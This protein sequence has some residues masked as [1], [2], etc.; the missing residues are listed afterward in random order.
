MKEIAIYGKGG[1]GKSTISANTS[2]ALSAMGKNVLQ[3]GCDPKHDSTRL[4]LEGRTINTVL[5]YLKVTNPLKYQLND[6]LYRGFNGIGCIEAGGPEPGVGCAG[7]GIL[8]TFE[9]LD[10]LNLKKNDY[11]YIIY[12][13]LGD[14]VCGG[15]AVP[16]RREYADEIYIVTSG[17]FMSLY[18]ANNI[19]RGIKNYVDHQKR[20]GGLI[21]NERKLQGEAERVQGFA[22]AVGLPVYAQIPRDDVFGLCEKLGKTL[23]EA[24]PYCKTAHVFKELA[25]DI[26]KG[27]QLYEAAP[28][29][30]SE[31]ENIVLGNAASVK[32]VK[33]GYEKEEIQGNIEIPKEEVFL[34]KSIV[35]QEPLHGCAFNGAITM[36]VHVQDAIVIGHAPKS[37]CHITYQGITS[38]GRRSLFEKGSL[39]P[40]SI[41]PN[42]ISTEMDE[43]TMV[44][45]GQN[46]LREKVTEVKKSKPKGIIVISSCPSGIIGDDITKMEE[47]SEENLPVIP[48]VADGNIAGDY[49]QGMILSYITL[50]KSLI[51]KHVPVR[52][53]SVN[54]VFEKVVANNTGSNFIVMQK[55]LNQLGIEVNCRYICE[56]NVEEIENFMAAPL[57]LLAN[58]DYMGRMMKDFFEKEY[59]AEFLDRPFPFGLYETK[60]WLKEVAS[61]FNRE[62]MTKSIIQSYENSYMEEIESLKQILRGK[63]LMIITFNHQIDWILETALDLEMEIIKVGILHYSQ[64]DLFISRFSHIIYVDEEYDPARRLEDI[65]RLNPDIFISNYAMGDNP[66]GVICDTIPHCP[67]V[68]FY[69]G[70]NLAKRWEALIG[71]NIQEGWRKDEKLFRKYYS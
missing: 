48:I 64:D 36:S 62:Y 44:F 6:I 55:L 3:I 12:D 30:D 21:F 47:L 68:G 61:Y 7:R 8:T 40:V 71:L 33:P 58:G 2:A 22:T 50:A 45:G 67:D 5:D 25:Q 13:V 11:D 20:V 10:R 29:T 51:R 31:L 35:S 14:V 42:I 37:C 52:D 41:A 43:N 18:A 9:L 70:L 32:A 27:S 16:I 69:S 53:N 15:F 38:A 19:L 54:I 57:N 17:E 66:P 46:L 23:M 63:K 26:I 56:T 1:I 39:L 24:Y 28:L 59:N 49:L 65:N 60:C 34:S 4:L